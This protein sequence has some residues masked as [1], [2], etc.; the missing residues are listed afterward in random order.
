MVRFPWFGG[1]S[2]CC[3][4]YEQIR[5]GKHLGICQIV[6]RGRL[7]PTPQ[8]NKENPACQ[9]SALKRPKPFS[10]VHT[11]NPSHS[12]KYGKLVCRWLLTTR[13]D[14]CRIPGFW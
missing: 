6:V 11:T 14:R 7:C 3:A 2:N 5:A 13:Q 12:A 1:S 4:R 8:P 10:M 9:N